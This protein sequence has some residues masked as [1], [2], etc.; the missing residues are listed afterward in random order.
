D[1]AD[2]FDDSSARFFPRGSVSFLVKTRVHERGNAVHGKFRAL[3]GRVVREDVAVPKLELVRELVVDDLVERKHRT[4]G[5]FIAQE[6]G[7][8]RGI[9][10]KVTLGMRHR[11]LHPK[12]KE[13]GADVSTDDIPI[14]ACGK[15]IPNPLELRPEI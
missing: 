4:G 1:R 10:K 2:R 11:V 6:L 13:T 9:E 7:H 3:I 8:E 5:Q 15:K 12:M 14:A